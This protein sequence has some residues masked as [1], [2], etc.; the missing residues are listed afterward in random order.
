MRMRQCEILQ[1]A[2]ASFHAVSGEDVLDI[3]GSNLS[4]HE[5]DFCSQT[6][7]HGTDRTCANNCSW[8]GDLSGG[9][10]D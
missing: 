1:V 2:T 8:G 5:S 6:C 3:S 9:E 4:L 7:Q 10:S